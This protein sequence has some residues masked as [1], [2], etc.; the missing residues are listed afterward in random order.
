MAKGL[1]GFTLKITKTSINLDGKTVDGW[2]ITEDL[3]Y[4]MGNT[5]RQR[6]FTSWAL[7]SEYVEQT[8]GEFKPLPPL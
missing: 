1:I 7:L 5:L 2:T 4:E 8:Y 3:A 6:M